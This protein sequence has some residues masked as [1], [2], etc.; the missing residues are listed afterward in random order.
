MTAAQPIH[1][2]NIKLS[3]GNLIPLL[4]RLEPA[5]GSAEIFI[6]LE[7]APEFSRCKTRVLKKYR[8][9][10]VTMVLNWL[11]QEV[12]VIKIGKV[13]AVQNIHIYMRYNMCTSVCMSKSR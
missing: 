3:D 5:L 6:L 4:G 1:T 10:R 12:L 13:C 11:D 7:P 9:G 8:A 2:T